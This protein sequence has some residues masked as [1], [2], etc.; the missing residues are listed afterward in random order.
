MS[1][2]SGKGRERLWRWGALAL[3]LAAGIGLRVYGLADRSMWFD[4]S[5]SYTSIT[6]FSWPEMIERTAQAVHPP[7]YYVV[8][9]G[10]AACF[11]TSLVALRSL[12]VALA[13]GTM[14]GVY[15]FCREAFAENG[16]EGLHP[17]R[18]G[19]CIGV[20][21]AA[22]VAVSSVHI[23]WAQEARMYM[24]GTALAAVSGWLLACGLRRP[25]AGWWA[26]YALA[27]A[28]LVYTHNY[29]LFTVV[30][31]GCV[32]AGYAIHKARGSSA[33]LMREGVFR[34]ISLA[35]AAVALLYAPWLPVVM[36][37]ADRV[38]SDYWIGPL[39]T[40]TVPNAWFELFW[41]R[42]TYGAPSRLAAAAVVA[43]V[44]LVL[45]GLLRRGRLGD[46][47]VVSMAA[48]PV[49][50]AV[51]MSL[52]S[53]SVVVSRYFLF[54]HV[55]VLC[56]LARGVWRWLEGPARPVA[57]GVLVL[58]GLVIH[59]AYW[60]ELAPGRNAGLEA[61]VRHVME[62]RAAA[63]PLV[64]VHPALFFAVRYYVQGEAPVQL[65]ATE[66]LT[67]YNGGPLVLPG[68]IVDEEGLE[69]VAG[70]RVW[71]FDT[72]GF[73]TSFARF[74]LPDEWQ[75]VPGTEVRYPEVYRFQGEVCVRKYER[76]E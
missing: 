73:R 66:E 34:R 70:R 53:A 56:G 5:V 65:Y 15:L 21:A 29:G 42:N 9:R 23:V 27:A 71:V 4:E 12:S 41:P 54:A 76:R 17:A 72:T 40:W 37:Q 14:A 67:H 13:G 39:R 61:A 49:G 75:P 31:Q 22:L 51:A 18:S 32:A 69:S 62:S 26:G 19:P 24:L 45:F 64:V 11:G 58:N 43:A 8:L 30:A 36:R 25:G 33:G 1:R 46:W 28:G 7:L 16:E 10:W 55:F 68:D 74:E 59:A 60:E 38:R 3:V 63:E 20:S 47:L 2:Q 44:L 52:G 6:R 57:I 35:F 48:V 50:C